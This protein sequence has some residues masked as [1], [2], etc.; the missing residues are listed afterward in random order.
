MTRRI[1][2]LAVAALLAGA[3][4]ARS[5]L[6]LV[7]AGKYGESWDA[8]AAV[9]RAALTRAQ[10]E[11]ALE[12][13]RRPLGRA[14]SRTLRA[15]RFMTDLPGAPKGEYV[16]IQFDTSFENAPGKI[17]TVTPSK[18]SGGSWLVSGYYIK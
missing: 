16:V 18:E 17:E 12:K 13:V 10:W 1:A 8:A 14:G 2:V 7:D 3:G 11:A 15:A 9:F 5:W 4:A 6:A